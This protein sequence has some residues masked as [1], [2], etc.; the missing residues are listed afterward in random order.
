VKAAL[1]QS[2]YLDLPHRTSPEAAEKIMRERSMLSKENTAE[3]Y[4]SNRTDGVTDG[5]G[6]A[7][8]QLRIP[9]QLAELED[10]S[11]RR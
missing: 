3:V 5:Y 11:P 9:Q 2:E 8:V 6:P 1:G 10:E 4:L 7:V